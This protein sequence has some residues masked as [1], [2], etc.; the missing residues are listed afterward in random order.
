MHGLPV[1]SDLEC[2]TLADYEGLLEYWC[3]SLDPAPVTV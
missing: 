2:L 3:A 1:H